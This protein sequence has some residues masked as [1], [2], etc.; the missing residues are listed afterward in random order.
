MLGFEDLP[1]PE[2]KSKQ[3]RDFSNR[4]LLELACRTAGNSDGW[5][6]ISKTCEVVEVGVRHHFQFDATFDEETGFFGYHIEVSD[7]FEIDDGWRL[8]SDAVCA[9][10][11]DEG[12]EDSTDDIDEEDSKGIVDV[13]ESS[14]FSLDY[15]YNFYVPYGNRVAEATKTMSICLLDDELIGHDNQVAYF[16]SMNSDEI[17]LED[18][19]R[20]LKYGE[21]ALNIPEYEPHLSVVTVY[22]LHV[23]LRAMKRFGLVRADAKALSAGVNR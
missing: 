15:D 5:T 2:L 12:V 20:L 6:E 7:V 3:I 22:D 13:G 4:L 21:T 14:Y 11:D 16:H 9:D 17:P 19:E 10:D 8:N 23:V 1:S 18:I